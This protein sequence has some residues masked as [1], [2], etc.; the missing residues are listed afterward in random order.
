MATHDV[1]A[2]ERTPD[3]P[4]LPPTISGMFDNNENVVAGK[5]AFPVLRAPDLNLKTTDAALFQHS[6]SRERLSCPL[7]L[8]EGL[9]GA[10]PLRSQPVYQIGDTKPTFSR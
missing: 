6:L 4:I 9:F 2:D 3:E 1:R 5:T 8:T 10:V 7:M